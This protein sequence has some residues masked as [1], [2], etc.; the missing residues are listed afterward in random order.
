MYSAKWLDGIP[1]IQ[2]DGHNVLAVWDQDWSFAANL[3]DL[4]N[5]MDAEPSLFL[6]KYDRIWLKDLDRAFGRKVQHV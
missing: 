3:C 2:R 6:N 5:E 4:L 1:T